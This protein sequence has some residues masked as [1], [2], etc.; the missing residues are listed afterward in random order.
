VGI[1]TGLITA[2]VIITAAGDTGARLSE[3][4]AGAI[5]G[6]A[7]RLAPVYVAPPPTRVYHYYQAPPVYVIST[8]GR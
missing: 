6:S 7:L 3:D 1:I 8:D 5:V 4:S 2:I